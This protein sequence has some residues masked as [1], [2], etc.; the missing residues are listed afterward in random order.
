VRAAVVTGAAK[1]IG[2][3]AARRFAEEGAAALPAKS[4]AA[5]FR[6]ARDGAPAG[7]RSDFAGS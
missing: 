5:R 4:G 1:G 2:L 3:A 7:A 6:G